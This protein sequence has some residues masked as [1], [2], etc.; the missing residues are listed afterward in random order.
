V[1]KIPR[2]TLIWT[3]LFAI[4]A[5]ALLVVLTLIALG[6]LVLPGPAPA[7]LSVSE[8]EWTI[9]QGNTSSGQGWFGPNQFV[10]N[11]SDG[12]PLSIHAGV[13]FTIP[14]S[15]P[16]FDSQPHTIYTIIVNS[17]FQWLESQ[18]RPPLPYSVPPTD[19]D[20]GGFEFVIEA[21]GVS[22][23]AYPLEITVCAMTSCA[24]Q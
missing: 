12:Y 24:S 20:E 21:S 10:W 11:A 4:A 22:S 18:S 9:I 23:G 3:T 2:R 16:N 7:K 17:P 14:W 6:Y 19:G 15:P 1:R 8:V 5:T 13:A